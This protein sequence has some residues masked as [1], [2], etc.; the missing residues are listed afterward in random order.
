MHRSSDIEGVFVL[1]DEELDAVKV[2]EGYEVYYGEISGKHSEV[3]VELRYKD[4]E[5]LTDKEE[6]IAF[7]ERILPHG[8]G[9][10]FK[11]YWFNTDK[12]GEEGWDA[13]S[14]ESYKDVDAETALKDFEMYDNAI[15][16]KAFIDGFNQARE[17]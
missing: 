17:N 9:F 11:G 3:M 14:M 6:E 12:A 2:L 8:A 4:I 5:I 15:M 1:T 7:F 13:G 10:S 16:R